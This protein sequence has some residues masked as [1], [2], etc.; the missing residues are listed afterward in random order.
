MAERGKQDLSFERCIQISGRKYAKLHLQIIRIML[1]VE[2]MMEIIRIRLKI[3]RICKKNL[4]KNILDTS[5][6]WL[7]SFAMIHSS[8]L[9]QQLSQEFQVCVQINH[10]N[11]LPSLW[12][13][14]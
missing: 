3:I 14:F 9:H 8:I 5:K 6:I 11:V 10:I 2:I 13:H 12:T 4:E 7:W 1:E